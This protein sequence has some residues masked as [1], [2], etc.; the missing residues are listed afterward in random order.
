MSKCTAIQR[1]M[2]GC[3]V[4]ILIVIEWDGTICVP[5]P[6]DAMHVVVNILL[7][8]WGSWMIMAARGTFALA[9][10]VESFERSE[11]LTVREPGIRLNDTTE[12]GQGCRPYCN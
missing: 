10:V 12:Y 6:A 5:T 4:R 11:F 8:T 2:L 3:R 7:T 9:A 1:A